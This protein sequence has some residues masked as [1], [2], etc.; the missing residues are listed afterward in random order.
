MIYYISEVYDR[1]RK[2]WTN[3]TIDI[4]NYF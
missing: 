3:Q 2:I 4:S 1:S